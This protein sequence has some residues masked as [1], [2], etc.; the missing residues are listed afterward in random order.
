MLAVVSEKGKIHH[1]FYFFL[2][3]F[4]DDGKKEYRF[5]LH[6]LVLH[7]YTLSK[8][9]TDIKYY[10]IIP[11]KLENVHVFNRGRVSKF[12]ELDSIKVEFECKSKVCWN[13]TLVA[14]IKKLQNAGHV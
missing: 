6:D 8:F 14:E 3:S 11:C 2:L 9:I 4:T 1:V 13:S 10:V 12:F 5:Y 7:K